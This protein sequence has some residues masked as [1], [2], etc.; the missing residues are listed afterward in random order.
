[1][2]V[3]TAAGSSALATRSSTQSA[4]VREEKRLGPKP[5]PAWYWRWAEWRLGEGYAKGHP[6]QAGLRPR[7]AAARI[8]RWAWR[9]LHFFLVARGQ[10]GTHGR[11]RTKGP[12]VTGGTETYQR[13]ISYTR[14]R[15]SFRPTRIVRV[16]NASQLRAAI[17]N[18]RAGD[19]VKATAPFTV[20]S[21]RGPALTIS[22]RLS[23]RAEIDLTGVSF[24]YT[25][26]RQEDGV[27]IG[28]A[29]NLYIFGGNISTSDT[30]GVCLRVYGSQNVLWWGWKVH[31]CGASGFQAQAI[32]GPVDH[33]DFQGEISKVGQNLAWD[34][35]A[36][37]GTGLH[38][39]NLWDAA[40]SGAF[41]NN[42][43]AFYAHDIPV[44]ACV[45]Y[46]NS[47]GIATGD[48]LYLKCVNETE[49]AKT[50]T[51]GNALQIWGNINNTTKAT[52]DVKYLEGDNL[53]GYAYLDSGLSSG[54]DASGITIEYGRASNTNQNPR[55]RGRNPWQHSFGEIYK[56]VRTTTR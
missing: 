3:F 7:Q 44:G 42:R 32:G 27:H 33:D 1:M 34:P 41:T 8:P 31:D 51:G 39:A 4:V 53:Q 56:R 15:P 13:A 20:A 38:A 30:G 2:L 54:V 52:L 16:S 24:V 43:F 14:T 50:Q 22:A 23:A 55:Y 36:E 12:P 17:S 18:L 21:A 48:I 26:G 9:R 37:K 28:N 10:T 25:G 19:L 47:Q 5:L 45:E 46:G 40:T 29:Q 49:V 35:H 11:T 6:L